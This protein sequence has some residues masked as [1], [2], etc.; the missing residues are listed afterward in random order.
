MESVRCQNCGFKNFSKNPLC[1]GC[2]EL[3]IK[4]ESTQPTRTGSK[5]KKSE[6]PP[7]PPGPI[8]SPGATKSPVP[9]KPNPQ[10]TSPVPYHNPPVS[11][12]YKTTSPISPPHPLPHYMTKLG[13]CIVEG[14][15]VDIGQMQNVDDGIKTGDI[16][17]Y[18]L[19]S[20]LLVTKPV[21]GIMSLASG[22]RRTKEHRTIFTLRI[23]TPSNEYVDIR[24]EKDMI[25]ASINMRDYVSV[26]G[27]SYA[28]VI[29]L[30]RGYNHTVKGEIR[31]R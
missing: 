17:H 31:L 3:L 2:G 12:S 29:I 30:L 16:I 19:S 26:W 21:Y 7:P 9:Y 23:Q 5:N 13:P 6:T 28:G 18:G 10:P 4:A 20:I 15:V 14:E 11:P 24:I 8:P 27:K 1:S 25:G 22:A